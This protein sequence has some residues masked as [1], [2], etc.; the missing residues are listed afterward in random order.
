MRNY[1]IRIALGA[2]GVF[3][4]GMIAVTLVRRGLARVNDVVT[5]SGP[6][7]IPLALIP[8]QLNGNK[9]GNLQRLVLFRETPKKV[10]SVQLEVKLN[11]SLLARGLEGCRL[12]ANLDS[13]DH[14]GGGIHVRTGGRNKGTF[15]CVQEGTDS[16]L[17]EYGHA[18]FHPGEVTVPLLLPED[19]VND[20]EKG[21][22]GD[23]PDSAEL[24]DSIS[25]V[26]EARADSI[27]EAAERMADSISRRS[28]RLADSLRTEGQ[29]R[30]DSA[31]AVAQRMA[32]SARR[33]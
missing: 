1:W 18:I 33:R 28:E 31:R 10:S 19:L 30:A 5:G 17:V 11:D 24:A 3:A 12:A 6:L 23:H 4:V 29:R 25:D 7:S 14:R 20:L 9:L 26:V 22:F 32:D 13:E 16:G 2:L 8:F 21:D 27:A 15:W